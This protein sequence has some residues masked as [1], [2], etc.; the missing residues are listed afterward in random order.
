VSLTSPKGCDYRRAIEAIAQRRQQVE[1]IPADL[2]RDEHYVLSFLGPILV[3]LKDAHATLQVLRNNTWD[4]KYK[5]PI[6]IE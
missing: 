5:T 1:K 4:N 3:H 2:S 6:K